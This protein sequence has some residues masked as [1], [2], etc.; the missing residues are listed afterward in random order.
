MKTLA[1]LAAAEAATKLTTATIRRALEEMG[2]SDRLT[3]HRA[4]ASTYGRNRWTC[5]KKGARI[6]VAISD[7]EAEQMIERR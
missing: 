7:R 4:D 6:L 1:E 3:R 5:V 2:Y